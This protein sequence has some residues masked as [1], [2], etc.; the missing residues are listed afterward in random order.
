MC[1]Y[2]DRIKLWVGSIYHKKVPLALTNGM[3]ISFP[4]CIFM[5]TEYIVVCH[6]YFNEFF[7]AFPTFVSWCLRSNSVVS[8]ESKFFGNARSFF[9][10]D[11]EVALSRCGLFECDHCKK[12]D[13][14]VWKQQRAIRCFLWNM[15]VKLV[16]P[17]FIYIYRLGALLHAG[18]LW[19]WTTMHYCKMLRIRHYREFCFRGD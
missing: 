13:D 9:V 17:Y 12:G 5:L 1:V 18:S 11:F 15:S 16:C 8:P 10:E 14:S 6:I 2:H 3:L 19:N 4:Q 7:S